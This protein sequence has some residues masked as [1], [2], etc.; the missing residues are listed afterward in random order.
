MALQGQTVAFNIRPYQVIFFVSHKDDIEKPTRQ[1]GR[2][3]NKRLKN[4]NRDTLFSYVFPI[5]FPT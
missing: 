3:K 2:K 5:Y 1:P 4:Q